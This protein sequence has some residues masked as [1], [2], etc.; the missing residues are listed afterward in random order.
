M[1]AI[2]SLSEARHWIDQRRKKFF[3][4]KK[5]ILSLL[6]EIEKA[7]LEDGD[8]ALVKY[9]EKFDSKTISL[10]QD[11]LRLDSLP[12]A[13][14]KKIDAE[15]SLDVKNALK[16]ATDRVKRYHSKQEPQ[17][18]SLEE[19]GD[20]YKAI[21]EQRSVPMERV[22]LYV[23]G[24]TASYPSTVIMNAVPAKIA[25]VPEVYMICPQAT[26]AVIYAASLSGVDAIIPIGGAQAIFAV[27]YG[28]ESIARA[29]K[30]VGPGN[31]YVTEAKKYCYGKIGI[32]M[33]AGP[34]E[35]LTVIDSSADL[36][37]VA[38]DL[39]SQAEHDVLAS[40]IAIIVSAPG[41]AEKLK[42]EVLRQA[43]LLPRKDIIE[44]SLRDHS[45]LISVSS[46][47]EALSLVDE[48]ASE[49]LEIH[50]KESANFARDVKNAG[51]IFVGESCCEVLGD[52]VIGTNHVLP[53]V[54]SAKF[55]SPLSVLDFVKRQSICQID[56]MPGDLL[57]AAEILAKEE[58][59]DA[60]AMA[61][62]LRLN[63]IGEK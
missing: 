29:D 23:P 8:A 17:N 61:A 27:T 62:T 57:K 14:K 40:A 36:E 46:R 9:T 44:H 2:D 41:L 10:P 6:L 42:D 28:T 3:S 50:L 45:A 35:I 21:L 19:S 16:L 43:A 30:V 52:Y 55:E 53:T 22:A 33:P 15:L 54:G 37:L 49:H 32:D 20:G 51:A 13:I 7:I 5:E 18:F 12:E 60:H 34:S 63:K 24:G 25:G 11:I 38:A 4:G 56:G 31:I 58:G 26:A 59:L 47:S 39:L 1:K 48:I